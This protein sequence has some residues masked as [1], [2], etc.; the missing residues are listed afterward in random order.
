MSGEVRVP[1]ETALPAVV[2]IVSYRRPDLLNRCLASIAQAEPHLSVH[3]WDNASDCTHEVK[4]LSEQ[5]PAARWT[6][7][8][9][10]I[11]FAAAVNRMA[12]AVPPR[13]HLF[14]LNPDL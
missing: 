14:L 3:V 13:A 9:E 7:C 12:R 1:A 4:A 10:N 11:G 6:F 5:W 8:D 2:L